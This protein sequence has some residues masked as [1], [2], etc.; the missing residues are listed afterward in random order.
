MI[1]EKLIL[2][3][4]LYFCICLAFFLFVQRPLFYYYNR[5]SNKEKL[6]WK[7]IWQIYTH[8]IKTDL[9]IASYLTGFPLIITWIY[10]HLPYFDCYTILRIYSF[11][12]SL[13]V[14]IT[15]VVDTALYK[16]WQSK[17]DS[18]IFVYLRSLKGAFASVSLFYILTALV[19]IFIVDYL[20]F[21]SLQITLEMFK[22]MKDVS[23]L[24]FIE[25]GEAFLLFLL[26]AGLLFI[27]IRGLRIRPNNPSIAYFSKNVFYNHCALN[28]L[29]SLIYSLSVKDDFAKQFQFF[30]KA[31][32]KQESEKLFPVTGKPTQ[33]L[34]KTSR[35]NI[36]L[37]VWE[38]LSARFMKS[39]GG[40][41]DVTPN[42]DKLAQEGILFTRCDAGSFRTDRGLVCLLSGYLGQPTTSVIRYTRKLPNLPAFPR[43]LK[44]IGY[45][46]QAVHG[47]DLAIMHKSDYYLA[48]GHDTLISQT[49][50]PSSVPTCKWG[51]HDDYMFSWLY[52][53]IQQ[54]T[55]K[56]EQ[57]YTTFQTL[58]SHEPFVVP[59]N[60]LSSDKAAN[61]FAYTDHCL[62]MFV[63]KLKKTSAWEN[64]LIICTGDHGPNYGEPQSRGD[65]PH[66][67][68]VLLGG[69]VK[70]AMKIDTIMSQTDIAAT[71]LGQMN[72]P[73][74]EF[75]FSRDV[76][77]DTYTYPFSFHTYN[78]GFM[79]RDATGFTDFDN[80]ANNAVEGESENREKNGKIILQSLYTDLSER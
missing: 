10:T 73:H 56:G 30:D 54:K 19:V 59:Y 32:S 4:P 43:V 34:L 66:I 79:F 74:E 11:I 33:N 20:F 8:G 41:P 31:Y 58:S 80:V 14:A 6:Q 60:R 57:W 38:S 70:K 16:F 55:E 52:N 68:L 26:L 63:E 2:F 53:N 17:I 64:L 22:Q 76:L 78:N 42:L 71:L 49:D 29:Y 18:S 13:A 9:I 7:D 5:I 15:T 77:A 50:F 35:P 1:M 51:I 27:N 23:S 36:L 46:T 75:I 39:L 24:N 28:P 65:Y 37:I 40:T 48:S 67:P 45:T 3:I 25:H 61:S 47:G 72:L 44:T 62:G 69:A 12:I 21:Q